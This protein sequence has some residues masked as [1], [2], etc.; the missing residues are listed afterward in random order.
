MNNID[1]HCLSEQEMTAFLGKNVDYY[2]E[3]WNEHPN[4]LHYKGWN[5]VALIFFL[6]WASYRKMY[7][8]AVL[9][10]FSILGVGLIFSF[11]PINSNFFGEFNGQIIKLLLGAFANGFYYKKALRV[12]DQTV[13][14]DDVTKIEFLTQ[15]G[16]TSVISAIICLFF[17]VALVFLPS[18]IIGTLLS[19]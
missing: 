15:K 14:M 5:L 12:V 18:I 1:K 3:K 16:G 8:E 2:K 17:E 6:E 9:A 7:R 13:G 4:S 10:F 19:I 11:I